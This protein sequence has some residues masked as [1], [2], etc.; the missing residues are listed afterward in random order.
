MTR[1]YV[2]RSTKF[3]PW[4]HPSPHHQVVLWLT[5]PFERPCVFAFVYVCIHTRSVLRVC[6]KIWM[7]LCV[8][9]VDS[10][11]Q[12]K[13][14]AKCILLYKQDMHLVVSTQILRRPFEC[15]HTVRQDH[16]ASLSE[17]PVETGDATM[18][19]Q[20]HLTYLVVIV[21]IIMLFFSSFILS[22]SHLVYHAPKA[23]YPAQI[24]VFL[25][26][27]INTQA[28]RASNFVSDVL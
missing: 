13:L 2:S 15:C 27:L 3:Q 14:Y 19:K 7:C 10:C 16:L 17:T 12:L 4:T 11:F 26:G 24:F 20:V 22:W 1:R 9:L 25:H 18:I 8:R 28:K 23:F 21:L 5:E 6:P